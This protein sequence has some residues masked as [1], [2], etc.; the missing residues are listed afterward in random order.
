[1]VQQRLFC[2]PNPIR[3][4]N[5]TVFLHSFHPFSTRIGSNGVQSA[6]R[7]EDKADILVLMLI[8]KFQPTVVDIVSYH[9]REVRSEIPNSQ[10]YEVQLK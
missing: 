9:F 6:T 8:Q 3:S 2:L 5:G 10:H 1:M 7:V 4:E